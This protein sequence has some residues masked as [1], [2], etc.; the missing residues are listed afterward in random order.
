M[1]K[2]MYEIILPSNYRESHLKDIENF[3]KTGEGTVLN[4]TVELTAINKN[5]IE[6]D[7]ELS[8]SPAKVKNKN[9]FIAF[10]SDIIDRKKL[11]KRLI[12]SEKFL[13]S[14]IENIPSIIF[15]KDAMDFHYMLINKAAAREYGYKKDEI[16]GKTAYQI[17]PKDEADS[18]TEQDR[19]VVAKATILDIPEESRLLRNENY[20]L[21]TKKIPI[22]DN[23]GKPL[24]ILG[25]SENIT[26]QKKLED[27]KKDAEKMLHQNVQQIKLILENIGEGVIVVDKFGEIILSNHMADEIVGIKEDNAIF[28][29]VDWAKD[30]E[31]FYPDEKTIFPAQNLPLERALR[32]ESTNDLNLIIQDPVSKQKKRVKVS[33]S[34]IKDENN[35]VVGAVTTIKNVTK[36][37]ELEESLKKSE[38]Q[39]RNLIG[40]KRKDELKFTDPVKNA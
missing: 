40:F 32:G 28:T 5:N 1:G 22:T 8:I 27:K 36:F 31:L 2:L 30:F 7:I 21:H 3:L 35:N 6:F 23:A 29:P 39:Y 4:K 18:L 15:I 24:Y 26:E 38:A 12:E 37:N 19:E 17:F 25:I 11:E 34:P 14:I 20:W 13:Y 10:I 9:I 33:G 16:I